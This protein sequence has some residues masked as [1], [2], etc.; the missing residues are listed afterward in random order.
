MEKLKF[1]KP[2]STQ[3]PE[4]IYL[5]QGLNSH[6]RWKTLSIYTSEHEAL[7]GCG[8]VQVNAKTR[9]WKVIKRS[10]TPQGAYSDEE[11]N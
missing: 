2:T 1:N 8:H 10:F 3:Q 11:V 6:D 5:L 7:E 9:Q 4:P